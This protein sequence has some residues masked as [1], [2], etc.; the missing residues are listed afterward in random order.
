VRRL[1]YLLL[2]L[3]F[4][5][6]HDLWLWDEPRSVL[7]LPA[8]LTFHVLYCLAAAGLMALVVRYAWPE[9]SDDP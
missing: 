5:I 1:L 6:R 8:G 7:G 4:L 9:R 2:I 3:F